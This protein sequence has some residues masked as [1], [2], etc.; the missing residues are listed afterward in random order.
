MSK[1]PFNENKKKGIATPVDAYVGKRI[2]LKR[3]LLGLSQSDLAEALDITF[4]QVQ[5]YE[6][7]KNRVS[8]SKLYEI[9][10]ALNVPV[11]YFFDDFSKKSNNLDDKELISAD[12]LKLLKYFNAIEDT[13]IRK[14][15][16]GHVRAMSK[17][18]NH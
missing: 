12:A 2:K 5:K 3:T 15:I 8:S 14:S 10:H 4:Q 1:T 6:R 16:I 11:N 9:S 17:A 18:Y 13:S 7:G